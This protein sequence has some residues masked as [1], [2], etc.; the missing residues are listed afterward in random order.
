MEI[1]KLLEKTAIKTPNKI[2][3]EDEN[4]SM[5]AKELV[6]FA[7]ALASKISET[8]GAKNRAIAVEVKRNIKTVASF[9]AVLYSGNFFMPI[10]E[11]TPKERLKYMFDV[12]EPIATISIDNSEL[13]SEHNLPNIDIPNFDANDK[14][15]VNENLLKKIRE[16]HLNIDPAYLIF[17]SGST[18]TPKAVI[19][20]HIMLL[21]LIAFLVNTFD[22][23]SKDI[24]ANQSPFYFDGSMKD[25]FI[26]AATGA[27]LV[28][29][30]Q[31]YFAVPIKLVQFLNEKK[32]NSIL[33]ASS[34]LNIMENFEVFEHEKPMFIEKVFFAG[35]AL[36]VKVLNYWKKHI[37]SASY[38][39]LYGPTETT[40][41]AT[42]Y[43]IDR[44]FDNS[45][46]ITIGKACPNMEV[47]LLNEKDE[48]IEEGKGEIAIRGLGV[49]MGYYNDFEKTSKVFIQDPRNSRYRDIIYKTGDIAY[50][51]EN[52]ELVFASRTDNQ[53]KHLGNRIELGE[54]ETAL[55]NMSEI[56]SGICLYDQD[57]KII[58]YIYSGDKIKRK[59]AYLFLKDKIPKYMFPN[60][61]IHRE[62]LPLN[63][64][65]KI[66][67]VK[68]R[69]EY[70]KDKWYWRSKRL[71]KY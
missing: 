48:V 20:N 51:N 4:N 6:D 25:V 1:L 19:I 59:D 38:V 43:I 36:S 64:N 56:N 47:L 49:S 41:D 26:M 46:A 69:E 22:F 31:N 67:R 58:V 8:C 13:F 35:E 24:L 34:A 2:V 23:N 37:P 45:E 65:K 18:G 63:P 39:N 44:E 3:L 61:L 16:K 62:K 33:W 11:N 21:D 40:V 54:I 71:D 5:T 27:K 68:L 32:I 60:L 17:T 42:Y 29:I 9:F 7:K 52:R 57:K 50:Y 53:I 55:S 10:D 66:D 70:E 15:A 14:Y 30:P 12:A 28:I